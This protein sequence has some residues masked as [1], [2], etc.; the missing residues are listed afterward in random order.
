MFV[1]PST[2]LQS[3]DCPTQ[4]RQ[5]LPYTPVTHT[6]TL[7][8][9]TV[10]GGAESDSHHSLGVPFTIRISLDPH[11][12]QATQ[13]QC[14]CP[15]CRC[16][17]QAWSRGYPLARWP[18]GLEQGSDG[19]CEERLDAGPWRRGREHLSW[20]GHTPGRGPGRA[21]RVARAPLCGR[22][23]KTASDDR[24]GPAQDGRSGQ[25][26]DSFLRQQQEQPETKDQQA[27]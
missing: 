14:L 13:G 15:S 10:L 17:N 24:S 26:Q 1:P 20:W 3:S 16:G 7:C 18:W 21:G 25:T 4:G 27:R 19:G 11:H 8:V 9:I 5:S 6:L 23:R 12:D 2:P 22:Q